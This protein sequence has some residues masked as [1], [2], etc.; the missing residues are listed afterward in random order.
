MNEWYVSEVQ[1]PLGN[2][3]VSIRKF[4]QRKTNKRK[5]NAE[6]WQLTVAVEVP[7]TWN[8]NEIKSNPIMLAYKSNYKHLRLSIEK[9][10]STNHQLPRWII[11]SNNN[12]IYNVYMYYESSMLGQADYHRLRIDYL[13]LK[14]KARARSFTILQL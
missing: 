2:R 11:I 14:C 9:L 3:L 7:S 4:K 13:L 6:F 10:I 12:G 5:L 8:I 1:F